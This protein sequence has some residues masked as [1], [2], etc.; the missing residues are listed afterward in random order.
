MRTILQSVVAALAFTAGT[1]S[2]ASATDN[3]YG[4]VS[5]HNPTTQ[6]LTYQFRW[7]DGDWTSYTLYPGEYRWHSWTYAYA[8]ENSSPT[9]CIRY[10][11]DLTS[12]YFQREYSLIAYASPY[13]DAA[14]SK[15]YAFSAN[16]YSYLL[17]LYS[18][19]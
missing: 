16:W 19:N 4:V 7:G 13:H 5:I 3:W 1:E 17:S 15:Q 6:I 14:W 9:P 10:D 11:E 18:Q 8:N 12:G 2:M